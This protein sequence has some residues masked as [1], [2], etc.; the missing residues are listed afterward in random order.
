LLIPALTFYAVTHQDYPPLLRGISRRVLS[1][2]EV[3]EACEVLLASARHH[4]CPYWL[5]DGRSNPREQQ[6]QLHQWIRE[7]YFPRVRA[8]LKRP[9]HVAF[10]VTPLVRSGLDR[11]G[12]AVVE[13]LHPG[14]GCI[15][16]F[17]DE[18][19]ALTWLIQQ[20]RS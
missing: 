7:E 11:L 19:P 12:F 3:T 20:R 10:V 4:N 15:G 17:A 18:A 6:P 14:V 8:V 13:E 9:V 2:E 16:W 5:L 1:A